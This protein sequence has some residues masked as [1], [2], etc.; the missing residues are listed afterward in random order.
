MGWVVQAAEL[1]IT[2]D[3]ESV[4][5]NRGDPVPEAEFWPNRDMLQRTKHIRK[6]PDAPKEAPE[7]KVKPKEEAPKRKRGRP[8]KVVEPVEVATTIEKPE[9]ESQEE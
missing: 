7:E 6:L 3:G 1:I 5:L 8:K 2:R 9:P 4:K